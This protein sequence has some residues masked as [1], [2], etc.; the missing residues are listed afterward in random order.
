M[1]PVLVLV[2]L[3]KVRF[4]TK[5]SKAIV[6]PEARLIIDLEYRSELKSLSEIGMALDR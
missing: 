5:L 3:F 1:V 2:R 6:V 4:Y